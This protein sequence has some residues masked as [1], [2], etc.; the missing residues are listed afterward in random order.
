MLLEKQSHELL[1]QNL[2]KENYSERSNAFSSHIHKKEGLVS[3][4]YLHMYLT[5]QM[6]NLVVLDSY[7]SLH[8]RLHGHTKLKQA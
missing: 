3:P 7:S 2:N 1:H 4:K 6:I 5:A 8:A